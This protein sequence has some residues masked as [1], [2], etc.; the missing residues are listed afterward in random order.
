MTVAITIA[1]LVAILVAPMVVIWWCADM[2]G[3]DRKQW[4][5][6]KPG[7]WDRPVAGPGLR[8]SVR[9]IDDQS[10]SLVTEQRDVRRV[11]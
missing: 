3:D 11:R 1:A 9:S 2:L 6:D 4:R 5:R 8:N 10:P 7:W